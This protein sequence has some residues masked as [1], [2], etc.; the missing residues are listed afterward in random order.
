M[1]GPLQR[2]ATL[3]WWRRLGALVILGEAWSGVEKSG[4]RRP[5]GGSGGANVRRGGEG[6]ANADNTGGTKVSVTDEMKKTN[7]MKCRDAKSG[8]CAK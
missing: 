6:R 4:W 3:P 7:D 1:Q 2:T 5:G 8:K